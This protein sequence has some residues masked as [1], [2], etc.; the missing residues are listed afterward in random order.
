MRVTDEPKVRSIPAKELSGD[1]SPLDWMVL[2]LDYRA[3]SAMEKLL[4]WVMVSYVTPWSG[5][6]RVP[7]D[8]LARQCC[9]SVSDLEKTIEVGMANGIIT[10]S[11]D[12]RFHGINWMTL[13][14]R[15][16]MEEVIDE[17]SAVS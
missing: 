2:V 13:H 3:A 12:G 11:V 14:Q 7:L 15:Q 5:E 6:C 17:T 16:L 8:S 10:R 4:L 1:I 9:C